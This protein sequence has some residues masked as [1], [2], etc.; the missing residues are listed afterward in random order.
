MLWPLGGKMA[1]RSAEETAFGDRR[2][3]VVAMLEATWQSSEGASPGVEWVKAS[4]ARL[5]KYGY[6]GGTYLNLTD[7]SHSPDI[8]EHAYGANYARLRALKRQYDPDNRFRFNA[9]ILPAE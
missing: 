4:R 3:E 8:L 9:N 7:T 2:A 5:A 1:E 6:N